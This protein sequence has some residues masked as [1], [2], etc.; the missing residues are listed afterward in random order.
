MVAGEPT[1]KVD[2]SIDEAAGI[3]LA[4]IDALVRVELVDTARRMADMG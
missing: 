2:D 1:D 4:L 3:P